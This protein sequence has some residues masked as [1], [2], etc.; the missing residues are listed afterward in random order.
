MRYLAPFLEPI[1]YVMAFLCFFLVILY[2]NSTTT[3]I[4][5]AVCVVALLFF[6]L[7]I[8]KNKREEALYNHFPDRIHTETD[9]YT[10]FIRFDKT[11]IIGYN[12]VPELK[13][14][15]ELDIKKEDG[16][17]MVYLK[18]K[19]L[20]Y[21]EEGTTIYKMLEMHYGEAGKRFLAIVCKDGDQT[22]DIA[23]YTA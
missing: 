22:F 21:M 20:G 23:L 8:R 13:A 4:I 19:C 10:Q 3:A 11:K 15:D 5:L 2:R 1:C 16:K 17:Y 6:G 14:K 12:G 9:I 18:D 7:T